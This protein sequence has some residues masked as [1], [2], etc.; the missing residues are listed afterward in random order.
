MYIII[1]AS[2]IAMCTIEGIH[3]VYCTRDCLLH[4]LVQKHYLFIF[5]FWHNYN[6]YFCHWQLPSTAHYSAK[7]NLTLVSGSKSNLLEEETDTKQQGERST[8]PANPEHQQT[9]RYVHTL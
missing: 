2:I 3:L 6:Y 8:V 4:D 7:L 5:S 9:A 1:I